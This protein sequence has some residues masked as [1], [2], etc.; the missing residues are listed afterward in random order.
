MCS[1]TAGSNGAFT[2]LNSSN[3]DGGRAG[4]VKGG[5]SEKPSIE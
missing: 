5:A 4:Q 3:P 1:W 2:A